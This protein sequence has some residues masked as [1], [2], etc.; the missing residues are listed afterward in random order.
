MRV[1]INAADNTA[2]KDRNKTRILQPTALRHGQTQGG[3]R[4]ARNVKR[5]RAGAEAEA[6]VRIAVREGNN[7][8]GK[9][10]TTR[11]D[12]APSGNIG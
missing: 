12:D 1:I 9:D 11:M 5:H 6:E 4:A 10:N 2:I 8:Q 7:Q 3:D